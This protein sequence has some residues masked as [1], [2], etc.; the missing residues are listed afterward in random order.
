MRKL[1]KVDTHYVPYYYRYHTNTDQL[2]DSELFE[3]VYAMLPNISWSEE[4]QKWKI[5]FD[6]PD[7]GGYDAMQFEWYFDTKEEIIEEMMKGE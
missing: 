6:G 3:D 7:L 1:I 2:R 4:H 5:L